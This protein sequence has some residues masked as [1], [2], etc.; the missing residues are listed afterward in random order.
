MTEEKLN[1]NVIAE[2]AKKAS[3]KLASLPTQVKNNA[4]YA[5]TKMCYTVYHMYGGRYEIRF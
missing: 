2:N 1:L 3:Y 5:I 4:L